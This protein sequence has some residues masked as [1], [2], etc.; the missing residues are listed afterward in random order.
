M[1]YYLY[2]ILFLLGAYLILVSDKDD[3]EYSKTDQ[4]YDV[5]E[6]EVYEEVSKYG[7][8]KSVNVILPDYRLAS[9]LKGGGKLAL[10]GKGGC[11]AVTFDV[12]DDCNECSAGLAGRKFDGREVGVEVVLVQPKEKEDAKEEEEEKP[13]DEGLDDF[14]SSLL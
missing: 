4:F 7:M 8:V 6:E 3:D 13:L 11:V 1:T 10:G 9:L 14:F 5:I 2:S 12:I